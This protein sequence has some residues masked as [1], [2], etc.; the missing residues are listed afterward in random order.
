MVYLM[1]VCCC[2]TDYQLQ[3]TDSSSV[4][5]HTYISTLYG[6]RLYVRVPLIMMPNYSPYMSTQVQVSTSYRL[7]ALIIPDRPIQYN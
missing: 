1:E 4:C 6:Q 7:E 5:S 3:S 2:S